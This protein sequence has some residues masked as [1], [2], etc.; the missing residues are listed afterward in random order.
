MVQGTIYFL[1]FRFLFWLRSR[2]LLTEPDVFFLVFDGP[3][4]L[5]FLFFVL[6]S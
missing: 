1:S 4:K 6:F 5:T 3:P 2:F